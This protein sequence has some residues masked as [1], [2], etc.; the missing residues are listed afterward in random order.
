[1]WH[2][3]IGS[4]GSQNYAKGKPRFEGMIVADTRKELFVKLDKALIE[5]RKAQTK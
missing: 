4:N 3:F 2:G 5:W 1:M